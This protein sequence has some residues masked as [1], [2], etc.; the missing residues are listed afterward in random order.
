MQRTGY[1]NISIKLYQD[2]EA[3]LEHR[4]LE[5]GATFITLTIRDSLRGVNEGLLQIYDPKALHT[6]LTGYEIIQISLSTANTDTVFNRIYGI[7]HNNATIDQKGDNI[8]T[9]QLNSYHETLN[10][11][12][13]RGTETNAVNNITSMIDAIYKNVPLWKP[14]IYGE[15]TYIP[16]CPWVST[17]NDY[18]EFVRTTGQSVDDASFVYCWEDFDGIFV[19]GHKKI[20][21]Q[22]PISAVVHEPTLIGQFSDMS[23]NLMVFDFEWKT[24]NN[25]KLKRSF[26]NVS[27]TT[28][29]FITKQYNKIIVGDGDNVAHFAHGGAYGDLTY[30]NAFLEGMKLST[31]GQYDSYA[32]C[33]CSGNFSLRPAQKIRFYDS[34]QQI[35]TDFI[36]DEVVHEISREQS[37]THLYMFSNSEI[38]QDVEFEGKI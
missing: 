27:Y 22:E 8:I 31:F 23:D 5:L 9:F 30:K 20:I 16:K 34:K 11:K 15:N 37:L 35:R 3:F 10:L 21:D 28:I 14:K 17:I 29:D 38:L 18:M 36:V 33:V 25:S 6:K 12:F 32:S 19:S 13:S 7:S 26:N 2:Y 24:K 4:F 1:P